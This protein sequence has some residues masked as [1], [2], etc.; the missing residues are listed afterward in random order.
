MQHWTEKI[1]FAI[2]LLT[3]VACSTEHNTWYSRHYQTLT[4]EFNVL[5]NGNEAY[6]SGI[7]AIQK[8]NVNDY[9][10]IL[11]VYEFSDAQVANAGSADM[12]TAL[13]KA[14]KLIQLHSI[15]VKPKSKQ[16]ETERQK[17][18]R[19]QDEFNPLVDDAS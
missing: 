14:H 9:S 12:E 13:K 11:P 3:I 5:F 16:N 2:I 6:K 18:F 17:K 7:L 15:T 4:S 10:Y 19:A 1:F 8:Q